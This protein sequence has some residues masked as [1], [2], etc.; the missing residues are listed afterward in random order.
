MILIQDPLYADLKWASIPIGEIMQVLESASRHGVKVLLDIHAFP[1]GSSDGTY[2]GIWPLQPEFWN[3][4]LDAGGGPIYRENF[5]TIFQNLIS[6]AEGLYD[7]PDPSHAEGLGGLSAMNEP[8]HLMG[9]PAAR[10]SDGSWGIASYQEV[11]DTLA[12]AVS[13]FERSS[14]PRRGVKLYMNVIETM[15]PTTMTS[16]QIYGSIGDWWRSVTTEGEREAWAVL[17]I[18]HY[19]AWDGGCNTCLQDF[20]ENGVIVQAGFDQMQQCSSGWYS[21]IRGNLA[22]GSDDLLATSEFIASSNSDTYESCA[23][24]KALPSSPRNFERYRNEVLRYQVEDAKAAGI[25]LYFWTW[26][27]PYNDNY[28]NE[29]SLDDALS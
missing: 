29:W 18:H 17:D 8:A 10:C 4:G 5:R 25:D 24:G 2:N 19:F 22:L 21:T 15:F 3:T 12:F 7:L 23:S 26:M 13:D 1:G 28:Q 9:I 16:D 20:V 14:P 11:L 6:W 27:I